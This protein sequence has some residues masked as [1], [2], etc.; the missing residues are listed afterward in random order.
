ML[1]KSR[2]DKRWGFYYGTDT[3]LRRHGQRRKQRVRK[4]GLLGIL[5]MPRDCA[6]HAGLTI[7]LTGTRL[8]LHALRAHAL[9]NGRR[10]GR[11]HARL[12]RHGQPH[13]S[14]QGQHAAGEW[15]TA[16]A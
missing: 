14:K 8:V 10:P 15:V 6:A 12:Q 3:D 2:R 11:H 7:S 13:H 16:L 5:N 9:L 4:T 1:G